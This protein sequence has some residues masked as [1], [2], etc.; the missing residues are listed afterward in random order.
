TGYTDDGL[1]TMIEFLNEISTICGICAGKR[2]IY[3]PDC[4][5]FKGCKTCRMT[6]MVRCPACAGGKLEPIQW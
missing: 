6:Y 3:C 4:C 5:G 1:P 2:R